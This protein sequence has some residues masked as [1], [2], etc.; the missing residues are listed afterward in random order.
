MRE[1]TAAK[2]LYPNLA[3]G[4]RPELAQSGPRL[5]E[6]LYPRPQE[7]RLT[8]DELREAWR[9]HML[10]LMGLRRKPRVSKNGKIASSGDAISAVTPWNS[11]RLIS[12]AASGN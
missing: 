2:A 3:S 10:A 6:A 5:A 9:D 4:E 8:P 7:R 1:P 12:G 11:L